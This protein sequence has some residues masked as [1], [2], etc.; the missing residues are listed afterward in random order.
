LDFRS[1]LDI[2]RLMPRSRQPSS[3]HQKTIVG[4]DGVLLLGTKTDRILGIF[5]V[6][7]HLNVFGIML[8]PEVKN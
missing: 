5:R 2:E 6:H 3:C 1:K 7:E 4:H 8:V